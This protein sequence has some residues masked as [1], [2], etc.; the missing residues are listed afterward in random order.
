VETGKQHG[1]GKSDGSGFAEAWPDPEPYTV[2]LPDGSIVTGTPQWADKK[3]KKGEK[4]GKQPFPAPFPAP[5]AGPFAGPSFGKGKEGKGLAEAKPFDKNEPALYTEKEPDPEKPF[6]EGQV[7][8]QESDNG[9]VRCDETYRMYGRDVYMWKTY[10][11]QV[12]LG[13]W[14]KFQIHISSK[15]LPQVCWI[16]RTSPGM[17]PSLPTTHTQ[18][19][20]RAFPQVEAY[21]PSKRQAGVAPGIAEFGLAQVKPYMG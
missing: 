20:K 4:G 9:F 10:F 3:G 11:S 1:K 18:G 17:P 16:Q 5:F 8:R 19:L 15:G 14:V 21:D 12:D 7:V 2:R 13:D 6:H